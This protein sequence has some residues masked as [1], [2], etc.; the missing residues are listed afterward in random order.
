[1][2]NPAGVNL[3]QSIGSTVRLPHTSADLRMSGNLGD[4]ASF[5]RETS[6]DVI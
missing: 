5:R 2:P 4:L 1:M 3:N 6:I